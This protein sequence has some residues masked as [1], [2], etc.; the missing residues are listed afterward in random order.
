MAKETTDDMKFEEK[1]KVIIA[2]SININYDEVVPTADLRFELGADSLD[3]E[4]IYEELEVEFDIS[5]KGCNSYSIRT[6]QDVI[7]YVVK[8]LNAKQGCCV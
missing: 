6:V 3:M 2:R 5:C 8:E 1:I 7:D 4:T